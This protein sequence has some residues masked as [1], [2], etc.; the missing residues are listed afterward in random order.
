MSRKIG[1]RTMQSL[2]AAVEL[3]LEGDYSTWTQKW[4]SAALSFR[5]FTNGV[6]NI[7]GKRVHLRDYQGKTAILNLID[8]AV[9]SDENLGFYWSKTD[10]IEF[11]Q[12]IKGKYVVVYATN[13]TF[14]IYK[15][16]VLQQT[17]TVSGVTLWSS[18]LI[19]SDGKYVIAQDHDTYKVYCFEGS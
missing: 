4:I 12:S 7:D 1:V 13:D 14:R 11:T 6:I 17:I 15:D 3:P 2:E 19:S 16:G 9:I 10:N 8:G 5:Q 18:L